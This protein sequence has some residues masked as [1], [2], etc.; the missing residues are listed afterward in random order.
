MSKY[1]ITITNDYTHGTLSLI[2]H[3]NEDLV[4]ERGLDGYFSAKKYNY[5]GESEDNYLFLNDLEDEDEKS[6]FENYLEEDLHL[7]DVADKLLDMYDEAITK[8]YL[9]ED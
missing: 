6:I 1:K 3:V 5:D 2:L 7:E 4:P 8:G 9:K